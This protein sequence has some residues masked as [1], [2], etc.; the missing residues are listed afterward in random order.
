MLT[1]SQYAEIQEWMKNRGPRSEPDGYLQR[2]YETT[3]LVLQ[4]AIHAGWNGTAT[5]VQSDLLSAW[6]RARVMHAPIPRIELLC[7]HLDSR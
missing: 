2:W 5:K 6:V 3:P 4:A 7:A 1:A